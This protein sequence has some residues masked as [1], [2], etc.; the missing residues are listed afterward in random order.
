MSRGLVIALV[1]L[2]LLVGGVGGV[3]V[4][5]TQQ[6]KITA[7]EHDAKSAENAAEDASSPAEDAKSAAED[8]GS[9]A[10]EAKT[11]AEEPGH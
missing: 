1:L 5:L 7:A 3:A 11:A 10:E 4:G 6:S 9:K 8:A 2:A